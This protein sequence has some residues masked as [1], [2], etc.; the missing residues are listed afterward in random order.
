MLPSKL[1]C[2]LESTHPSIV[3]KPRGYFSRKLK[4][5]NQENGSFYK[6]ASIPSSALLASYKVAHRITKCKKPHTFTEEL[7]LLAAVDMV[8]IMIGEAAHQI[9]SLVQHCVTDIFLAYGFFFP[10]VGCI[11]TES[12]ITEATT[13]LLYQLQMVMDDD[14]CRA[15]SGMLGKGN[16]STQRKLVLMLLYPPKIPNDLT[17]ATTVGSQQLTTKAMARPGLRVNYIRYDEWW[18]KGT[19]PTQVKIGLYKELHNGLLT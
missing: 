19:N 17:Q 5:L 15:V 16:Q 12:T 11:G 3:S 14:E 10:F 2:H 18:M 8:S 13:G 6:Q 9:C 4:E 7:I 1:K